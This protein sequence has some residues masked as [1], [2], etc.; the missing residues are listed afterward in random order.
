MTNDEIRMTKREA[1]LRHSGFAVRLLLL[2]VFTFGA[3][4]S[5][6]VTEDAYIA[7]RTADNFVHG[8][9]LR[10]NRNERVQTYTCPLYLL[11][12]S[13][14]YAVTGEVY[15]TGIYLGLALSL[16]AAAVVAFRVGA[17]AA[18][19]ILALTILAA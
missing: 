10:W 11:V 18:P 1:S 5:A 6:W 12:F 14:I 16:A 7:Y 4:R 17:R 3:V 9:G 15:Y 8:Y 19:V 2:A 13:G